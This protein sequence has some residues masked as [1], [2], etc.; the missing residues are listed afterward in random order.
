LSRRKTAKKQE[1]TEK[2]EQLI[3]LCKLN[4]VFSVWQKCGYREFHKMVKIER[5]VGIQGKYGC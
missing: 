3:E 2:I 1:E 5:S 4:A